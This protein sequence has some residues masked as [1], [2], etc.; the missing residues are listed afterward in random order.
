M[1]AKRSERRLWLA[2]LDWLII[3]AISALAFRLSWVAGERGLYPFDQSIVFDGG[4]RVLCG[5]V[6]YRDFVM[7]FGPMAFWLQALFFRM[8]GVTYSAYLAGAASVNLA[9]AILAVIIV[10]LLFPS[11]RW[12]SYIAG[13][14]TGFWFYPPFGT[15]WVD[16]TS[17]FFSFAAISLFVSG[18][19]CFEEKPSWRRWALLT[20]GAVAFL[21]LISKQNVGAFMLPLYPLALAVV[22]GRHGAG[23]L[24]GLLL[25]VLGLGLGALAFLL[26][27]VLG[28]DVEVFRRYVVS[29]P[30]Q[31]GRERLAIFL[32][33]WMGFLHPFFGGRGPTLIIVI[34]WVALG[35]GVMAMVRLLRRR[36]SGQSIDR[37]NLLASSLC[38]YLVAFQHLFIN[39][40][41]NQPENGLAMVGIILA[42]A[43]GLVFRMLPGKMVLAK[44]AL[45]AAAAVLIC[46]A[47][48]DGYRVS[49][50]R[51]VHD[52]FRGS[53]F[54]GHMPLDRLRALRWAQ[55]TSMGGFEIREADVVRL[56]TYLKERREVF[57]VFPDFTILY[58]LLG[59]PSPQPLLWF[60][61]GV[62][63]SAEANSD[64]DQWIVRDLKRHGVGL[65][66]LEQV[67][68]FNTGDRLADFPSMQA[69]LRTGFSKMGQI[70]IFS[71]YRKNPP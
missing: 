3:L 27:L 18:T 58:G 52:I 39:T 4:Y 21:S 6:P 28:S 65:I 8:L 14:I 55:P 45:A 57:F 60:H 32:K 13:I 19:V 34:D 71:V 44:A 10:R 36:R 35:V 53:D 69:Y 70:G 1:G 16:Q 48:L 11:P 56:Y 67:S 29:I 46:F 17:F 30:S 63:Y 62:T 20:S 33:N 15:P 49:M 24:K 43:V 61:R 9:A 50:N 2:A 66:I 64:L 31:L 42:L 40:T 23:L 51:K 54:G 37:R 41:L 38:I 5:Q 68:W 25:F 7:P 26:W 59:A 12:V 47:C 22:S